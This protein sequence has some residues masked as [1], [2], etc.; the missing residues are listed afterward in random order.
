MQEL[1]KVCPRAKQ[2]QLSGK[3]R[4]VFTGRARNCQRLEY[5]LHCQEQHGILTVACATKIYEREAIRKQETHKV[6]RFSAKQ[7]ME[8]GLHGKY[9]EQGIQPSTKRRF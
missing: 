2:M 5:Y 1:P 6:G 8:D 9:T 3:I 7:I 4:E